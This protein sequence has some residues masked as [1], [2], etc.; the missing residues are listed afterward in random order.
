MG[1]GIFKYQLKMG[2]R[3]KANL[4]WTL[5]FPIVL[6]T[7]FYIAFGSIYDST[8]KD[9]IA[10]AYVNEGDAAN[11]ESMENMLKSLTYEDGT[12]MLKIRTSDRNKAKKLIQDE[13]IIGT[14]IYQKDDTLKLE[15]GK[16]EISESIL[17]EIVH[18]FNMRQKYI[19]DVETKNPDG[20]KKGLMGNLQYVKTK[21]IGGENK[22]PYVAYFYNLIAMVCL[23]SSMAGMEI[24][25]KSQA[26]QSAIGARVC[27]SPANKIVFELANV[28]AWILLQI[29]IVCISLTYFIFVLKIHFGGKT[30]LIYLTACLGVLLGVSLGF[31]V[32]HI[33]RMKKSIRESVLTG[34]VMFCCFL[35]GLMID[36]MK[37]MIEENIPIL[38]RINPAA[39]LTDAFYSL[40]MFGLSQRYFKNLIYIVVVSGV[41]LMISAVL[42][43]RRSYDE[44]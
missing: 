27:I 33:G 2:L 25:L 10:I 13:Q 1:A 21:T 42:S 28:C 11:S 43:G 6:G 12:A 20:L 8:A 15:V 24:A 4:F 26:N 16:N 22:D 29:G 18:S 9:T 17:A 32:G 30:A 40:N 14:I 37:I 34:G 44:L 36:S 39:V 19:E 7:L 35:S 5:L 41:L 23:L 38:N 31:F 3:I